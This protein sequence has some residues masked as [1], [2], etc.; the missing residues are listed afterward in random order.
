[1]HRG[2]MTRAV[3]MALVLFM[4]AGLAWSTLDESVFADESENAAAKTSSV[5]K[6]LLQKKIHYRTVRV[7]SSKYRKTTRRVKAGRE[8]IRTLVY[9]VTRVDGEPISRKLVASRVS[10]K[11]VDRKI[12][13]GTGTF[14][15][16]K[17]SRLSGTSGGDVAE[18]ALRFVGNPYRYGGSSLT[19]GAD[20]S[21]FVMSV[22]K[23]F[24]VSLPHSSSADRS[25]GYDVGGL[26]NAQPGD[27]V[28]YSGHVGIYAGDGKLV[29]ASTSKTGIIVSN[30]NYR[31]VLAVRRIF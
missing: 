27:I 5:E 2:F 20:C 13:Y 3:V 30:A 10:R 6:Q 15:A 25:Q 16:P 1:M 21:G 8:G 9:H 26:S 17:R 24:G 22:Y 28:C 11:A 23:N 19:R 12:I 18:F 29:H 31:N 7:R 14:N 4:T